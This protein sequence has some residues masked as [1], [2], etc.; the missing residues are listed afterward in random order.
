MLADWAW[1]IVADFARPML[2]DAPL[3]PGVTRLSAGKLH[4]LVLERLQLRPAR[5][6]RVGVTM[7]DARH[8]WAVRMLRAGAPV[9]IVS[10]QLGH[11]SSKKTLDV[12]GRFVPNY[13]ELREWE[14]RATAMDL[15]RRT[16][17]AA[18]TGTDGAEAKS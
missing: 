4:R 16:A 1:P 11:A 14:A 15:L 2:P 5:P 7:H 8:H 18:A 12:Y 13:A 6:G 17:T 3:F 9:E 10:R